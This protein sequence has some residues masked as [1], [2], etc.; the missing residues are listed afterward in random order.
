MVRSII[1][2]GV[3]LEPH[4]VDPELLAAADRPTVLT[5]P[6]FLEA[7][8]LYEVDGHASAREHQFG[9]RLPEPDAHV[10]HLALGVERPRFRRE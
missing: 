10:N 1:G 6:L 8:V 9:G 4:E 2:L 3:V 7:E 5:K